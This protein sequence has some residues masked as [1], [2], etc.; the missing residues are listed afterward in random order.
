[1]K[2]ALIGFRRGVKLDAILKSQAKIISKINNKKGIKSRIKPR[3]GKNSTT[4][5]Q[6]KGR[7]SKT[8]SSSGSMKFPQA[9][10][11]Q[12]DDTTKPMKLLDDHE[13]RTHVRQ[14]AQCPAGHGTA[15]SPK[16]KHVP[17]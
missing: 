1:M 6:G 7:S 16:E 11:D 14:F 17:R 2:V 13:P 3:Y 15:V 10:S 4:Y 9:P 12:H 8:K 5:S